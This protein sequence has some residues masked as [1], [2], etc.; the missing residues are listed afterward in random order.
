[1]E[2]FSAD[3][4]AKEFSLYLLDVLKRNSSM[5]W[6]LCPNYRRETEIAIFWLT[7]AFYR[8]FYITHIEPMERWQRKH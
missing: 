2:G 7:A 3:G 8:L 1:V 5:D 6:Y 4:L